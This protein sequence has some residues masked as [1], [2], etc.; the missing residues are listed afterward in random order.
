MASIGSLVMKIVADQEDIVAKLDDAPARAARTARKMEQSFQNNKLPQIAQSTGDRMGHALGAG[1]MKVGKYVTNLEKN[2]KRLGASVGGM[3]KTILELPLPDAKF[4]FISQMF[5]FFTDA[6]SKFA[7]I[8]SIGKLSDKIGIDTETI[9]TLDMMGVSVDSLET[10]FRAFSRALHGTKLAGEDVDGELKVAGHT[11]NSLRSMG[12][13]RAFEATFL[14]IARIQEPMDRINKLQI[15][16]GRSGAEL[17]RIIQRTHGDLTAATQQALKF[18]LA[19]S[20]V[21]AA[22]IE[23]GHQAIRRISNVMEG[24]KTQLAIGIA[25]YVTAVADTL[26]RWVTGGEGA[27]GTFRNIGK[28]VGEAAVTVISAIGAVVSAIVDA[29]ERDIKPALKEMRDA[30]IPKTVANQS[31]FGQVNLERFRKNDAKSASKTMGDRFDAVA[32]SIRKRLEEID[33]KA[34]EIGNRNLQLGSVTAIEEQIAKTEESIEKLGK[35]Y[36]EEIAGFG[37]GARGKEIAAAEAEVQAILKRRIDAEEEYWVKVNELR[38]KVDTN[39]F[40]LDKPELDK[41]LERVA[42]AGRDAEKA[43]R[44]NE[45]GLV[46]ADAMRARVEAGE[47]AMRAL[48]LDKEAVAANAEKAQEVLRTVKAKSEELALM[49]RIQKS[50][51]EGARLMEEMRTPDEKFGAGMAHM[52]KLLA[53]GSI[54]WETYERATRKA[55]AELA[56]TM[57]KQQ[58]V[59]APK[60]IAKGS[61]A[62]FEMILKHEN[63][64][65]NDPN[66]KVVQRLE[67]Q[68]E[69]MRLTL[70][71]IDALG[72]M[73]DPDKIVNIIAAGG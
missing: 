6:D 19:F 26:E 53:H 68:K 40:V 71:A 58:Q 51:D 34:Q 42:K 57:E 32:N 4:G 1:V 2:M 52:G 61:A 43:F 16:F 39:L 63:K 62:D 27:A 29:W 66:A 36:G 3:F 46:D 44:N 13:Q 31:S 23:M 73:I 64:G 54:D 22:K 48:R 47:I 72:D 60:A 33:K 10:K 25:P 41:E 20:R 50:H 69:L 15:A 5:G 55:G 17:D 30:S 45:V 59:N 70:D 38:P 24:M 7:K 21:D 49:E 8:A 18:G 56:E 67:E 12:E 14:S 37:H 28:W 9:A 11:M 35:R 65:Q